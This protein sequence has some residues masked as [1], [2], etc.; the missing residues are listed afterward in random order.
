VRGFAITLGIGI[1]TSV[2]TA[3]FVTRLITTLWF[4][5]RRPKAITV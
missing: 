5:A 3:L 2:F 4:N 1:V